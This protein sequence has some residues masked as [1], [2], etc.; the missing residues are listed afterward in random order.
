[1][2]FHT[3]LSIISITR[4]TSARDCGEHYLYL[5]KFLQHPVPR[6]IRPKNHPKFTKHREHQQIACPLTMKLP[7]VLSFILTA[8][9]TSLL[10]STRLHARGEPGAAY[11]CSG[12]NWTGKCKWWESAQPFQSPWTCHNFKDFVQ[13]FGPDPGAICTIFE[14]VIMRNRWRGRL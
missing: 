6:K 2:C 13:S 10:T 7:Q 3:T 8:I 1:M 5:Q 9:A 12:P 11:F 4:Q 14:Y